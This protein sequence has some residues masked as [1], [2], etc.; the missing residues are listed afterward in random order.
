MS[1]HSDSEIYQVIE[2]WLEQVVIGLNLCPFAA[3][4]QRNGQIKV[5]ICRAQKQTDLIEFINAELVAL[6]KTPASKVD[7]TL[8]VVPDMLADFLDYNDFLDWVDEL[9]EQSNW[10][11]VYQV[12][13]FHPNYCFADTQPDDAANLTNRSPF[14]IYH[15][16]REDSLEQAIDKYPDVDAIPERNIECMHQLTDQQKKTLFN[17]G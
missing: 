13:S 4:P 1:Q 12:A 3:K 6:D 9:I 17:I 15:L 11:G 5:A 7:T 16:L 2:T 8:V 14:P 10:S